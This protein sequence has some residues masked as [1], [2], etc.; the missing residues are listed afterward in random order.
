MRFD[1]RCYPGPRP[2]GPTLVHDGRSRP[3]TLSG[4]PAAPIVVRAGGRPPV[5]DDLRWSFAYGANACVDRLVDKGLDRLGAVLLPAV[6]RGVRAVWEARRSPTH[7]AVPLTL[8]P[9]PGARCDGW[10]LGVH[11][12]DTTALD[13][14]EGRGERYVLATV[15]SVDVAGR[16]RAS[17]VPTYGPSPATRVLARD[18]VPLWREAADQTG[19]GRRL[20]AGG[21]RPAPRLRPVVVGPWPEVRLREGRPARRAGVGGV[22]PPDDG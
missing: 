9:A 4:D 6:A 5:L 15:G 22:R 7:G 19:A 8:V 12:R 17:R 10:L 14:S 3:V 21:S 16:W 18:G 20:A 1:P 2:A 11:P 13:R